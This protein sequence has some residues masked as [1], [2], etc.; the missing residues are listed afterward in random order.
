[1]TRYV[2]AFTGATLVASTLALFL[3]MEQSSAALLPIA[4][5]VALLPAVIVGLPI[6]LLLHVL[7]Q[8]SLPSFLTGGV[9]CGALT[10]AS[11]PSVVSEDTGEM[12][13]PLYGFISQ[14]SLIFMVSGVAGAVTYWYIALGREEG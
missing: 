3:I 4:F 12:M 6:V 9:V 7:K 10:A 5:V 1:M 14:S 2:M 8:K 13:L 11:N